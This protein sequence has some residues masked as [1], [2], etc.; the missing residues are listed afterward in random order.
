MDGALFKAD[1]QRNPAY[2]YLN[3]EHQNVYSPPLQVRLEEAF[4]LS[5]KMAILRFALQSYQISE[6]TREASALAYVYSSVEQWSLPD[7]QELRECVSSAIG[8]VQAIAMWV[9]GIPGEW[10]LSSMLSA[11]REQG[12]S[13]PKSTKQDLLDMYW[14]VFTSRASSLVLPAAG[15]DGDCKS[16]LLL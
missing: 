7:Y 12:G 2:Y 9:K 5:Y 11:K 1:L 6:E 16:Y 3:Q 15:D 4:W 14:D 13:V 10:D 8:S